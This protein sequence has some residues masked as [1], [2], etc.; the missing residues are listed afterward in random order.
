MRKP[1]NEKSNTFTEADLVA[2]EPIEQFRSWFELAC[3][4]PKIFEP[5]AMCLSTAT[6][7]KTLIILMSSSN[8]IMNF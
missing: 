8:G 3:Q 2:K 4:S 5:N 7:Y 6:K 1:Y